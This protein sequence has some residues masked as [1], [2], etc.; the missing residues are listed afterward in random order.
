MKKINYFLILL[1]LFISIS[2]VSAE[3]GNFTSLQRDIQLSTDSIELTQNYVYDNSTDSE[4]KNGIF[5]NEDNF[6]VNGNGHTID[7][8]NQSRIFLINGSNVTLKNLNL[9]NGN[10]EI[11]GAILSPEFLNIENVTFISNTADM[12]AAI[13]GVNMTITSS[14][15]SDNHAN[16]GVVYS[17]EGDLEI[18]DSIFANTTGLKYSMVYAPSE[19]TLTIK[20]CAF[21]NGS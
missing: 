18:E 11:G 16:K 20:D 15:F 8:S 4:L 14:N 3:D 12:G 9:I 6:V 2:A 17:E 5:I 21:V 19:G 10:N 7:G 13:A 1:V